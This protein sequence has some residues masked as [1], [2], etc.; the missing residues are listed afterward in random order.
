M[1][2]SPVEVDR[3]EQQAT[4]TRMPL[5]SLSRRCTQHTDPAEMERYYAD[6]KLMWRNVIFIGIA[7]LGW[8]LALGII[9]PLMV[10]A[11]LQLGVKGNIQCGFASLL[12]NR[13]AFYKLHYNRKEDNCQFVKQ[14]EHYIN[15][16]S[17]LI[18]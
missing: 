7:N 3:A 15:P 13:F 11:L 5:L 16:N 9:G 4:A 2:L 12:F 10:T 14:K 6:R 17:G 18:Y 8:G 1:R